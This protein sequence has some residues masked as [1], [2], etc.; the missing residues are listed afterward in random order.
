MLTVKQKIML[1]KFTKYYNKLHTKDIVF[2][3]DYCKDLVKK[4]VTEIYK[5]YPD[6]NVGKISINWYDDKFNKTSQIDENTFCFE[7]NFHDVYKGIPWMI[8]RFYKG[9]ATVG[10]YV[11]K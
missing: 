3:M 10:I 4:S 11:I 8:A 7:I 6:K 1:E 5:I 9:I 2:S